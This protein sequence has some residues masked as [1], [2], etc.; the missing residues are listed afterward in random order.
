MLIPKRR[1]RCFGFNSN[2]P[3][4]RG[5]WKRGFGDIKVICQVQE[6]MDE[7]NRAAGKG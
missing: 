1:R 5:T 2:Q 6:V 7:I 4:K 3:V